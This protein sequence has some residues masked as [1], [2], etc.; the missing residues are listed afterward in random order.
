ML[1]GVI[2]YYFNFCRFLYVPEIYVAVV[3]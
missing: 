1:I 2:L 3:T